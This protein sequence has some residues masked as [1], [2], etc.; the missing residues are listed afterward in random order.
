M[1]KNCRKRGG[2]KKKQRTRKEASKNDIYHKTD[3]IS[4]Y[5]KAVK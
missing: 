2:E 4:K 3:A 5:C 1:N